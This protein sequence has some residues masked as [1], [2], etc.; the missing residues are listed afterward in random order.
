M[1][2][3]RRQYDEQDF[4]I[5]TRGGEWEVSSPFSRKKVRDRERYLT[6]FLHALGLVAVW[7]GLVAYLKS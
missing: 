2:Y 4:M 7:V 6:G 1:S 5:F 3:G